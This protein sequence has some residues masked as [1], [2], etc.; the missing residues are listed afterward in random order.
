MDS[1][2]ALARALA[3]AI[4]QVPVGRCARALNRALADTF[5]AS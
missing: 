4:A 2:R 5:T 3:S 1:R